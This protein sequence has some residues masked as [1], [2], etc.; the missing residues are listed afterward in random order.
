MIP[1]NEFLRQVA[2]EVEVELDRLLPVEQGPERRLYSAMRYSALSG[3]KRLRPALFVA[4]LEAFGVER[5]AW[6][7]FAA[8]LEMIH[9][10]SLIHDDL[11]AMDNDDLRRGRPTCHRA[12]DEATAILAG[13]ALL[14]HAFVVML[15]VVAD[16]VRLCRAVTLVG[17]L[18]G[19]D[20]MVAGQA[21]ELASSPET[22]DRQRLDYIYQ[23]K[24]GAL[25]A[26]AVLS[27]AQLCG[28]SSEQL[29]ALESYSRH[30]GRAFQ[31]VD[32]VLDVEGDTVALGKAT[33]SDVRNHTL[34]YAGL[35]G[36]SA[37]RREAQASA[38][39]AVAALTRFD[40][41]AERL[42]CFPAYFISRDR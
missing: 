22:I 12:Y 36:C 7:P 42:R 5:H 27:A 40:H 41:R 25:L 15:S 23:G 39:A 14:T 32:D 8:G 24:T 29:T 31:I 3:G 13:D 17:R 26:C 1:W 34:T 35:L 11:P 2:E 18:A 6:M 10:Y 28:A 9:T 33:G 20:G 30:C 37:A 16:P 19:C 21:A 4:T 38:E